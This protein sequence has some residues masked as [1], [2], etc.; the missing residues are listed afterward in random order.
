MAEVVLTI[1]LFVACVVHIRVRLAAAKAKSLSDSP[2][3]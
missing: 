3:T 1:V 2:Q